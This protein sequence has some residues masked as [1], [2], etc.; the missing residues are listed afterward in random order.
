MCQAGFTRWFG[1]GMGKLY[2]LTVYYRLGNAEV[3]KIVY[4]LSSTREHCGRRKQC[5]NFGA[6]F[7]FTSDASRMLH[8]VK[9]FC[10]FIN[11]TNQLC[12]Y[13]IIS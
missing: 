6:F 9:M 11:V 4:F 7:I 13:Y 3:K 5:L 1:G 12:T 10:N 2:L 8:T